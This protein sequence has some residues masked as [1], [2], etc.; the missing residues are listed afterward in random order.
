MLFAQQE[1]ASNAVAPSHAPPA[2]P[3]GCFCLGKL[4]LAAHAGS[5]A[6]QAPATM[7]L[8]VSHRGQGV[9]VAVQMSE[10]YCGGW[11]RCVRYDWLHCRICE[12]GV[13]S[14]TQSGLKFPN[15]P[16]RSSL[17]APPETTGMGYIHPRL[18]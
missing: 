7:G 2:D 18:D 11:Q 10:G 1:S 14:G 6:A 17:C 4:L 16:W 5:L 13:Y 3:P 8:Q 15:S 9:D 12:R